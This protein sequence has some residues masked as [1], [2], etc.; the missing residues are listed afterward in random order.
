MQNPWALDYTPPAGTDTSHVTYDSNGYAQMLAPQ[1]WGANPF[2]AG[3][4]AA[5]TQMNQDGSYGAGQAQAYQQ[6]MGKMQSQYAGIQGLDSSSY[7]TF[8][9]SGGFGSQ[10]AFGEAPATP[11]ISQGMGS[12]PLAQ[13]APMSGSTGF[14]PWSLQGEALSR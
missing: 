4:N 13:A 3:I 14:N 8:P 7:P 12:A 5:N 9:N 10:S 6:N 2:S 11:S 1:N